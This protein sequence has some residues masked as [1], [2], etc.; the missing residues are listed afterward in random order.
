[1]P[2]IRRFLISPERSRRNAALRR[3]VPA[4]LAA[5]L[6]A[7]AAPAVGQFRIPVTIQE[8]SASACQ[9]ARSRAGG[10]RSRDSWCLRGVA[11]YRAGIAEVLVEGNRAVLKPDSSG[12]TEFTGFARRD[13]ST[14]VVTVTVRG[15]DGNVSEEKYRLAA[16]VSLDP[17][18][19]ERQMFIVT[20]L[21]PRTLGEDRGGWTP[22]TRPVAQAAAPVSTLAAG[23]PGSAGAPVSGAGDAGGRRR[24]PL[25]R[26]KIPPASTS[27]S[28]SPRSGRAWARAAS[29]CRDAARCAW[30]ATRRTPTALPAWRSTATWPRSPVTGG[31]NTS[32]WASFPPSRARAR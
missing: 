6:S 8:Y 11:Q 3:R 19:P 21:R 1:M 13:S 7:W 28:W 27:A 2:S 5:V 18:H 12:G 30:S 29:P 17:A 16:G 32:S 26:W 25:P 4:L 22:P 20:N 14:Q 15:T 31:G 24:L 10:D 9:E 23:V